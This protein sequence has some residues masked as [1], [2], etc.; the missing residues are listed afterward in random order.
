MRVRVEDKVAFLGGV[1]KNSCIQEILQQEIGR[2][3]F[4]PED[5]QIVGA[6]G[7]AYSKGK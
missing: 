2:P 4:I 5:P 6:L 7:C 3:L 1:A